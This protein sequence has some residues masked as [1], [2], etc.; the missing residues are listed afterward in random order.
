MSN[1]STRMP[2]QDD[3]RRRALILIISSFDKEDVRTVAAVKTSAKTHGGAAEAGDA[4]G[5]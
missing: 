1:E 3:D 2:G 4:A 5:E